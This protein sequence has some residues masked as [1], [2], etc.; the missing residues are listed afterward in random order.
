M[1]RPQVTVVR[2]LVPL[3]GLLCIG[4]LPGCGDTPDSSAVSASPS[5]SPI[6]SPSP[7]STPTLSPQQAATAYLLDVQRIAL[8]DWKAS[9]SKGL[10]AAWKQFDWW[11]DSTWNMVIRAE[12][13]AIGV[14]DD[15]Q[16]AASSLSPPPLFV[17]ANQKL[18]ATYNTAY[19]DYRS[20][21]Q[22]LEAQDAPMTIWRRMQKNNAGL[23]RA[24]HAFVVALRVAAKKSGVAIPPNIIRA[25]ASN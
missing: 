23:D 24:N 9:R 22:G 14:M 5:T 3:V 16:V 8:R 12:H 21:I 13:K 15:C 17:E 11:K 20:L 4:F 19:E 7:S 1:N 2:L 6:S 18:I 10:S 25:Y